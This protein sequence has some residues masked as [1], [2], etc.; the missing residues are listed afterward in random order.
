MRFL[1]W[2]VVLA[3]CAPLSAQ[4]PR[5]FSASNLLPIE[6]LPLFRP[7][8]KVASFSSYDRT[9]GNDDGFSGRYSFLRKEGDGLV[10]AE[11][12]G[13]GAITRIWTPTPSD[14]PIE[15]YFDG[16]AT[17]RLVLPFSDLFSGKKPP[18][19]A[20]LSGHGV[21]GY[22]TY[23]PL[24]FA[25]S[26]KIVVRTERFQFYM[27]NY[28]VYD[29]GVTVRSFEPGNTFHFA[30]PDL[31]GQKTA[32]H[33]VLRL[34]VPVTIF[35]TKKPGRIVS[36]KLSPAEAFAG[37]DRGIVMRIYWDDAAR[38]AVDV[39]VG[40]FF[41]YSFGKPT[42]RSLVVGSE[43]G[44]NYVRFPMPFDR[45]A[46]IE[47]VS[48]RE[49]GQPVSVQSEVT[50]SDRGKTPEEGFFHALWRRENPT[51]GGKPFTYLDVQ[52]HG[53]VAGVIL[54]AQGKQPGETQFFEGDEEATIDGEMTIHGTGSEDSF[55]GGWYDIPGRWFAT[56]SLPFSGCLEYNKYVGRTGGYRLFLG[57]AYSF[58]RSLLFT[59]E[60]SGEKN[61]IPTDYAST[62]FYY[63]DRPQ[64]EARPLAGVA[65]RAVDRPDHFIFAFYPSPPPV[66][67]LLG[68]GLTL[69]GTRVDNQMVRYMSF[70]Q[71]AMNRP[72]GA[73]PNGGTGGP[74]GPAPAGLPNAANGGRGGRAGRG[75]GGGGP[76]GP[77]DMVLSVD[78]LMAGDYAF[79][80][81]A[82]TGP[83]AGILQMRVND[84]PAGN[85]V[86]FYAAQ[87]ALSGLRP[88]AELHLERGI[89]HLYFT[90][91]GR[92]PQSPATVT[93]V[94]LVRI[95]GKR[96][97]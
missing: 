5:T 3:A 28:V 93:N 18:F 33:F 9:G 66:F 12:N 11:A 96:V 92:N 70:R 14:A 19:T 2:V 50:A 35:E 68:A 90:L 44:W 1:G 87:P 56:R 86:D 47:L 95:E 30:P 8:A 74:N 40:D 31:A 4:T 39:P 67:A 36:I 83:D 82:L 59:I 80:A 20:P 73:G 85:A 21:G 41:G 58:R 52:G 62:T 34:G 89:N 7:V 77:P 45:S 24:E 43:D 81:E 64:G 6:R 26:I 97:R 17:P 29:P 78:V 71:G 15:F 46:R 57:D 65:A 42:V 55:N 37:D 75:G 27:V 32:G 10:I 94:D 16:E 84:E 91:A 51:T 13:P 53:Q 49:G 38:P 54:Q 88:L 25:K 76:F 48:E 23:V 69:G 60:H 72:P 63:L 61:N 79:S 22:Y